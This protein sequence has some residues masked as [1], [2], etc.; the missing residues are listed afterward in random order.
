VDIDALLRAERENVD[1]KLLAN[2]RVLV[3]N[4]EK[5]TLKIVSEIPYQELQESSLGGS[6]GSTAFREVGVE[7]EVTAHLAVRDQM[8]RLQLRPVF[9]VVTGEVQVAGIGVT[10][11]Q[12]V[13]D[14]REAN[15]TLIVKNGQTVVLGGLKK[16]EVSKQIN[17]VPLLGDL[18]LAG[19]LFRF[20]AEETVNSELLVFIRPWIVEQPAL[21]EGETRAYNETEFESPQPAYTG[22]E[23]HKD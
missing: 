20:K 15:T 12:P 11:P 13:V 9:S 23:G 3:L 17:K 1:A 16:K 7:L 19:S 21:S 8:I 14:R 2:P 4:D 6:I 22:A 5:A 18:P 10:Y